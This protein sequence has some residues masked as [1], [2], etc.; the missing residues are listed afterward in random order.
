V[1]PRP[2]R[3][4]V[5]SHSPPTGDVGQPSTRGIRRAV[6]WVTE[7]EPDAA[8]GAGDSEGYDDLD[9]EFA[10]FVYRHRWRSADGSY[11][12]RI[13]RGV[14]SFEDGEAAAMVGTITKA[15][16]IPEPPE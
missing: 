2:L 4:T 3:A 13:S 1:C 6:K 12:D 11:A 5:L 15:N 8:Q 16:G 10:E 14:V 7:R 9:G